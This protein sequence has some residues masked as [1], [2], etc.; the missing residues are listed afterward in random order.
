MNWEEYQTRIEE[1][2]IKEKRVEKGRQRR[3]GSTRKKV[4]RE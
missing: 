2:V 4:K 3:E 1:R